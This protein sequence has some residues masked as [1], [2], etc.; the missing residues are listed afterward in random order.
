MWKPCACCWMRNETGNENR[1]RRSRWVLYEVYDRPQPTTR[2]YDQ[3]LGN[4]SVSEV[5]Q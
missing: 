4:Y 3:L 5:I 1:V 2:N